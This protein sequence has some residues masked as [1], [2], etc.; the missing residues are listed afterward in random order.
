MAAVFTQE[1]ETLDTSA[2]HNSND[3]TLRIYFHFR[4][5]L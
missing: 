5:V 2:D 1:K 3:L 4:I